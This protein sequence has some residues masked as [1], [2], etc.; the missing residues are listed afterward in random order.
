MAVAS[1]T[2]PAQS[3]TDAHLEAVV[4]DIYSKYWSPKTPQ[5]FV[6]CDVK[7]YAASLRVLVNAIGTSG[8]VVDIGGGW[9]VF[10]CACAVLGFHAITVDDC[11]DAGY[12][13]TGDPR[14]AMPYEYGVDVVERD[15]VRD[16]IDFE[17]ASI[18]AFTSFDS[19]EHW[20]HSPKKAF[21]QMMAALRPGGLFLISAPNCNDFGKRITVPL[22]IAEWSS[23][24]WWYHKPV[25]RSHVREPSVRDFRQIAQDLNLDNVRVYGRNDSLL[26]SPR[27]LVRGIGRPLDYLLRLRPALCTEIYLA[28]FKPADDGAKPIHTHS[29]PSGTLHTRPSRTAQESGLNGTVTSKTT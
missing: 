15:V 9:G 3:P 23:F 17:A 13:E 4:R 19:I 21:H 29:A 16:G 28:G 7:R 11:G 1:Q 18:D 24:D 25:F 14:R 8:T 20:H 27:A 22:G 12:S 26:L 10:S 6:E 2:L 5:H